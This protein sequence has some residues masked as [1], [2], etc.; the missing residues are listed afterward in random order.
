MARASISEADARIEPGV[1]Q[2]D[3]EVGQH[4]HR[5]RQHHQRLGQRVVLVLH[6]LHEQPA[7]AVEIEHLLGHHQAAD[8]ERE[9]DADQRSRPA[10]ARSSARGG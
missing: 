8:Q 4:E 7:D 6:R 3:H 2:V 10:A 5:D 1:Q 9:L